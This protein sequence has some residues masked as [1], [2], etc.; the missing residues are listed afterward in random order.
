[1]FN[2]EATVVNCVDESFDSQQPNPRPPGAGGCP[3][4]TTYQPRP[5]NP[6]GGT[7]KSGRMF[8]TDMEGEFLSEFH[9][10]DLGPN[11]GVG[12]YCRRTWAWPDGH[13]RDLLVNTRYYGG[14][15]VIDFRNPRS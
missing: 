7:H 4:M 11:T 5:W 3:N 9:V 14:V 13:Q 10:G 8:F 2:N 1:M 15:D 12:E 6:A